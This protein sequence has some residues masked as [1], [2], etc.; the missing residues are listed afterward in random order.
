M[1]ITADF[2]TWFRAG[3]Y[4]GLACS[5]LVAAGIATYALARKRGTPRQLAGAMLGCLAAA[6]CILPAIIWSETR[7]DL[8]GPALSIS[9]VLLWLAWV[10]VIGWMLPLGVSA[11]FLVLAPPFDAHQLRQRQAS[12]A[13]RSIPASGS[14]AER[15]H[16]PLG[17]G[18][19]WGRLTHLDGPYHNRQV[20]LSHQMHSLGRE[21]DNDIRLQTDLASRYHAELRFDH[22]RAYLL[23]RGSMNGTSV[24]GQ[25]I[26]GLAPLQD[27]DVLEVGGQRF[28]YEDLRP[29]A[30]KHLN[31]AAEGEPIPPENTTETARLPALTAQAIQPAMPVGQLVLSGGPDAGQVFALNKAILTIGRSSECDVIIPDAS[32]SRQHTQIIRQELGWYVQDLGSLNGTAINGQRLSAPQR[33]EDGDT[34]TIGDM[35]LLY[36][37]SSPAEE[38]TPPETPPTEAPPAASAEDTSAIEERTTA[39]PTRALAPK[40]PTVPL[41]GREQGGGRLRL[42][43]RPLAQTTEEAENS[44]E[45]SSAAPVQLSNHVFRP[46]RLIANRAFLAPI[47]PPPTEPS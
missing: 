47:D 40:T 43:T 1:V 38:S 15:Q 33:L 44:A 41:R 16:E 3:C 10:A 5:L 27:G 30:G 37:A 4:G 23:D 6:V 17:P 24:N 7:L 18:I 8:Q 9:E 39:T 28:R 29:Q 13:I 11:G 19:A 12:R 34:L 14:S 35:P 45:A 2:P 32:I 22:G 46:S 42:P 20:A 31:A 36:F 25:K 26:W 21:R